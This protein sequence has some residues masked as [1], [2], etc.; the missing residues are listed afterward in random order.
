[1]SRSLH[2]DAV[3]RLT[4]G[5]L[6]PAGSSPDGSPALLGVGEPD[7][8]TP[9]PIVR[10]GMEALAAGWTHY[11]DL[12][13]DPELRAFAARLASDAAGVSYGL[14][15]VL[16]TNG[17]TSAVSAAVASVVS[18]GDR[19]VLLD[20]SYSLFSS[21]VLM[22]GGEPVYVPLDENGHLDLDRI[23]VALAGARALILVNPAN[24]VGTVFTRAEL[25]ALADLTS[26][27]GTVVIADEVCDHFVFDG[28]TFISALSVDGWRDRL[29]Y[30]QS[31]SKTY[32]MTGWR[33]GY[34]VAPASLIDGVRMLH[35]TFLGAVNAAAQRAAVV[36]LE[37]GDAF[38]KPMRDS[39]QERRDYIVGR[40]NAM[41]GLSA[42][43][44]E[45]GFFVL[46]RYDRSTPSLELTQRLREHGVVVRPGREFGPAGEHHL[47]ISIAAPQAM[48]ATGLD[49]IE[50]Y[51]RITG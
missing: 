23:A 5:S 7:F 22:A 35:R 14:E 12:N 3:L 37:G 28:R 44:P 1:M 43:I 46:A 19:V 2:S 47:R 25:Q 42:R 30:C 27:H 21:A 20:P 10:A 45:G 32:A 29:V 49:R 18:P 16:V 39:Y 51:F 41:P 15:Q 8:D 48:L 31:L 26:R 34:L 17:A 36:A 9:E 6:R 24:P 11:G 50:D 4:A 38:V 40:V 33:V 13:G